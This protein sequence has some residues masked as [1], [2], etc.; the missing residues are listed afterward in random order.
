M[1]KIILF[2]GFIFLLLGKMALSAISQFA[3]LNSAPIAAE[4]VASDDQRE[5]YFDSEDAV[6]FDGED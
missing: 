6:E 4:F 5:D 2:T 1:K 3:E